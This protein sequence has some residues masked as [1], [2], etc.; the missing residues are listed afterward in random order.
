[1]K[2][3]MERFMS[4]VE[5]SED[6][7][8][9]FTSSVA[10]SGY[11]YFWY[12]QMSRVAHKVSYWLFKGDIPEGL[13][14]DHLCRNR[15]CVNPDH[16]EAVTPRENTLRGV[17]P[18]AQNARKSH[19]PQGHELTG[20]NLLFYR[21]KRYCR[22]CKKAESQSDNARNRMRQYDQRPERKAAHRERQFRRYH[23]AKDR[24]E[25]A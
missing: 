14:L 1:M 17:G 6:G 9:N 3:L 12:N 24:D 25:H 20:T 8:W 18:T 7:C 19:C 16:L 21:G 11:A 10:P 4:K 15:R 22:A 5:V 2:P 13:N 23:E